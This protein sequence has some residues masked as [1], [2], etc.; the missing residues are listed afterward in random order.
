MNSRQIEQVRTFNRMVTRR[1]G[2]LEDSYLSRGRPLGE[3]RLLFE[4]GAQGAEV[5]A[6]RGRLGLDSGYLSRLLRSLEAQRLVA[7]DAQAGDGRLRRARLT[8]KG[9]AE[10]ATYEALSDELAESILAPLDAAR[11]ERL[12]NAMAEVE[13]LMRASAVELRIEPAASADAR[14]CLGEYFA[15]LARRFETGFEPAKSDPAREAEMTPPAG[16]FVVARLD[17]EPVGCGGLKRPDKT[18]GEIKRVWAASSVRRLGVGRRILR[19]LEAAAR[20]QGLTRL[21]LDTNRA[22]TEA[23]AMYRKEGYEEVAPFNDN[24]YAHHWF[25][26]RL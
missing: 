20:E 4:V 18:I 7:V 12:V 26:K 19:M 17:G 23:Q 9:Q 14:W 11:R 21:R 2:A 1:V 3:A 24:P 13:R 16:V 25:E 6:L 15:E 5:R 8:R 22:L 10:F